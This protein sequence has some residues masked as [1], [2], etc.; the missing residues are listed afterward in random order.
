MSESKK[1]EL[2][3]IREDVAKKDKEIKDTLIHLQESLKRSQKAG[4]RQSL[5]MLGLTA[6]V[7]GMTLTGIENIVL[8]LVIFG[9]GVALCL[10]IIP[11]IYRVYRA[12]VLKFKLKKLSEYLF[13]DR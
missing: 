7:V 4:E 13:S 1:Q 11:P 8:G 9:V 5:Y 6:T 2:Q 3:A 12:I 10:S